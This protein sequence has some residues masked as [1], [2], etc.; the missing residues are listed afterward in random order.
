MIVDGEVV[1]VTDGQVSS[2]DDTATDDDDDD[3]D[4]KLS[5]V[6][7]ADDDDDD[8]DTIVDY[9]SLYINTS[10]SKSGSAKESDGL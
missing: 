4:E 8:D 1:G 10:D 5:D 2:L 9:V 3:D 7:A 6:A